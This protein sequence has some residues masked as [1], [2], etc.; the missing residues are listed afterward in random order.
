MRRV[1]QPLE[2]WLDGFDATS[3]VRESRIETVKQDCAFLLVRLERA[4]LDG[5]RE[6]TSYTIA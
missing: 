6:D 5:A 2:V 3:Q 4:L 1:G